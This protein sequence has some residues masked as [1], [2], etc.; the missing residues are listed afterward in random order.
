[1]TPAAEPDWPGKDYG[2][3]YIC[4]PGAWTPEQ[5]EQF[6]EEFSRRYAEGFRKPVLTPGTARD[7]LR[8][9]VTV[10]K[11]GE[12]LAVRLPLDMTATDMDCARD[13]ARRIEAETGIKVAFIPGEEFGIVRAE[14]DPFADKAAQRGG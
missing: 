6:R 2:Q 10:V 7:L 14:P 1:M 12:V 9:C 5:V 4:P 11:P 13:Y 3:P 8:E